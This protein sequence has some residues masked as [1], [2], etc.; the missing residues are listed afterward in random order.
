MKNE[1]LYRYEDVL[2]SS[3]LD[4]FD[5]PVGSPTVKVELREYPII[6]KTPKGTKID[7]IG[8][9]RIVRDNARNQFACKTIVE[10]KKS[11]ILRK[12]RQLEILTER[13]KY[14]KI[15]IEKA[16]NL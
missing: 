6:K 7:I 13:A 15:A 9:Y 10:A 4:E 3:G 8:K 5:N 16:K 11:F 14:V 2:Y 12:K 1:F